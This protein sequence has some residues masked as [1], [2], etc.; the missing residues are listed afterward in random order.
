VANTWQK[1]PHR[2]IFE[3]ATQWW[4]TQTFAIMMSQSQQSSKA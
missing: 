2:P 1:Y 3:M 4:D